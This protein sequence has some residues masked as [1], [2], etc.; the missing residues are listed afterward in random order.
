MTS[1]VFREGKALGDTNQRT[2]KK[3][4][5]R[6]AEK[7][8]GLISG[9]KYECYEG[10][11]NRLPDFDSL[12]PAASGISKNFDIS[13]CQ[14]G[15]RFGLRFRGYLKLARAGVY[16]FY[17]QSDDGSKLYIGEECIVDNDGLHASEEKNDMIAL[18]GG[19]HPISVIFFEK[20]GGEDLTVSYSGAGIEK[21]DIPAS[22]VF[23]TEKKVSNKN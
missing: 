1:Q 6:P 16:R 7:I 11:W 12:R 9:L 10:D 19:V 14:R 20:S 18:A 21:Q 17:L 22:A 3:V 2:F 13:L 4:S 15:E 8:E 23:H 5:A